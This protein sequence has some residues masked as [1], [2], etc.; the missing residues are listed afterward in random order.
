M[1]VR[2]QFMKYLIPSVSAMWFF[3]IYTMID[4]MFVGR[5]VGDQAFA[6]VT[7][8]MPYIN[9]IFALALLIAVGASTWITYFLG[10]GKGEKG[11]QIFTLTVVTLTLLG[12]LITTLSIVFIEPLVQFLGAT[13]ETF[14]YIKDYLTIVIS[15]STFFM[16]AYSLE[17][18][19]KADGYPSLSITYVTLAA[20]INIV[21]DYIFVIRLGMG[22][23]GAA[24]ATGLSQFLSCLAFLSHFFTKRSR[25]KFVRPS[26]KWDDFKKIISVGFPEALT[27]LSLGFTTFAF[28]FFIIRWVGP[29]GVTAFGVLVYLNNFVLMTMIGINQGMQPLI[30]FYNGSKETLNIKKIRK[31]AFKTVLAFSAFFFL[32]T[33][34]ASEYLVRLFIS[35]ADAESFLLAID[36]LPI[37]GLGFLLT[38]TNVFLSGYFTAMKEAKIA[39]T[40]SVMRGYALVF[41]SLFMMTFIL[42]GQAIW[43]APIVYETLTLLVGISFFLRQN[44]N[45]VTASETL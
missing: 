20:V 12:L 30:S 17:V 1:T 23:K 21:F 27:E 3:S 42:G 28:N 29:H 6:A 24:Y 8:A 34:L 32:L 44:K 38:G 33:Q 40:L 36:I 7:L 10:Q 13:D 26:F 11:N 16:V 31:L 35:P 18:L 37:F 14:Q 22:I 5:G 4:G 9:L 41:L 25:L 15:F 2:K 43:Y 45:M 19:V 39:S